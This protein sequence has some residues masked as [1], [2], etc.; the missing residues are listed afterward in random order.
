MTID[1]LGISIIFVKGINVFIFKLNTISDTLEQWPFERLILQANCTKTLQKAVTVD[2]V[3]I[4]RNKYTC[5]NSF[6][7]VKR[8]YCSVC[9]P[10]S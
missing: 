1:R 5:K 2:C 8:L 4:I 3:Q 9:C 10:D 7:L 6:L